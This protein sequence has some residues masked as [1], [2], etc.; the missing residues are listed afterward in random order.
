MFAGI[1]RQIHLKSFEETGGKNKDFFE[2][3]CIYRTLKIQAAF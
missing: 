1:L 2:I 3:G